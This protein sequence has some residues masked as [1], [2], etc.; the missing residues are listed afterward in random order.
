MSQKVGG[1]ELLKREETLSEAELGPVQGGHSRQVQA[2][3]GGVA[4]EEGGEGGGGLGRGS[5][6]AGG[7][8][9]AVLQTGLLHITPCLL[10]R[11]VSEAGQASGAR[12]NL[13][14]IVGRGGGLLG[15]DGAEGLLER[16]LDQRQGEEGRGG[17]AGLQQLSE[18]GR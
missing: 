5:L 1:V 13:P 12:E 16:G 15:Q 8:G 14:G 9:G 6:A 18:D 17:R 10:I 4:G 7:G 11:R 3:V 2:V